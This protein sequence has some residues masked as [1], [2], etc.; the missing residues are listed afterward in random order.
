M[1]QLIRRLNATLTLPVSNDR[2]ASANHAVAELDLLLDRTYAVRVG[3]R[4]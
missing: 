4:G 2:L 3:R 1:A